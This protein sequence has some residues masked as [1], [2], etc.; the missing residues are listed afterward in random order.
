MPLPVAIRAFRHR[1]YRLFMGGQ[2]ISLIGT[3][4]QTVAQSWLV[5]R[6]T[7]SAALLGMVG[8][9]T[10]IPV[11]LLGPFAGSYADRVDRRR[12]L[13][14]TQTMMMVLA[15]L[16]A[17][18]TLTGRVAIWHLFVLGSLLGVANA[19]DMPGRQVFVYEIVGRE[20]LI[21][22]IALN[23]S[24]VN[25]ARVIGPAVA[26]LL[27][28]AIGEGW[29]F[30]F[31]GVS[32]AAVIGGLLLVHTRSRPHRATQSPLEAAREGLG[33]VVRTAPVRALLVLLGIVSL[34]GM[35][36]SI[37]MPVV[38]DRVLH[39]GPSG[40]GMLMGATGVGAIAAALTLASRRTI[41]GLGSWVAMGCALFGLSLALFASVHTFWIAGGLLTVA[42]FSMMVQM[43]SSNTL[44]Q[45]MVPDHL[46]GRV[47]S[48]YSMMF[49]GMAPFGS[50]LAGTLAERIG[51]SLT[52]GVGGGICMLAAIVFTRRLP[53]LRPEAR[54]LILAQQAAAGQPEEGIMPGNAPKDQR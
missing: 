7:G 30:F 51:P 28:A 52:V 16:L 37:L 45:S 38:A 23:S 31:N 17:L 10:Q 24:M 1:D 34:A 50:L 32:Y 29:C 21:N 47:M 44:I 12:L 5:Y 25:G 46:R 48:V 36:Y 27:V 22:A 41:R 3:W 54:R 15:L 11:F 35:P 9:A 26:G 43:A 42:G 40:Y 4:M 33:F 6:L 53:V 8:F 13:L 18:L 19:Y 20:D 49:L 2:A 39:A 14:M